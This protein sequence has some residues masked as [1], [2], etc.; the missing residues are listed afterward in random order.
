MF[1]VS[2]VFSSCPRFISEANWFQN[3]LIKRILQVTFDLF[4]LYSKYLYE[5]CSKIRENKLVQSHASAADD[6]LWVASRVRND[7]MVFMELKDS[8]MLSEAS[9]EQ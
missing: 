2:S 8:M 5:V 1:P 9:D 7:L 4:A 6:V 3:V